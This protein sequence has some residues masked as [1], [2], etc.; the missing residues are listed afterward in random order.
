MCCIVP[1]VKSSALAVNGSL[2]VFIVFPLAE[3]P[4]VM[5]KPSPAKVCVTGISICWCSAF[6]GYIWLSVV[7]DRIYMCSNSIFP[8]TPPQYLW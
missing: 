6:F 7:V 3:V 5:R 8:V 1:L 2:F 4:V